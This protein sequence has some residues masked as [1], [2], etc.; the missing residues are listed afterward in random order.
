MNFY[1]IVGAIMTG[2]LAFVSLKI[3]GV[4]NDTT[5]ATTY[6]ILYLYLNNILKS[7]GR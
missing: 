1:G 3:L 7:N 4:N 6:I 5:T 2:C